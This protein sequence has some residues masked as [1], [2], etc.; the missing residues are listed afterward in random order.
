MSGPGGPDAAEA[1]HDQVHAGLLEKLMAAVRPEFRAGVLT[2]DPRDPVFGGPPCAVPGCER[3][4]RIRNLCWGHRQRW[5]QAGKPDLAVFTA[6]T[7]PDWAGHRPPPACEVPGCNYSHCGRGL[8]QKH[9]QQ[10]DRAGCP[11]SAA[12]CRPWT[13][14]RPCRHRMPAGC[15]P[16]AGGRC[17]PRRSATPTAR[18]GGAQAGQAPASSPPPAPIPASGA[19]GSTCAASWA[20]C[21]WR[22]ST[23]CNAAGT[24]ASRGCARS[25]CSRSCGTWPPREPPRCWNGQKNNGRKPG[26]AASGPAAA[27]SSPWTPVPGSSSW[28]SAAAG[29]WSTRETSGGCATWESSPGRK[30][31][32][33]TSRR[34]ASHG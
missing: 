23:C 31:P 14:C 4:A 11:A 30:S 5:H 20:G 6:A 21:G 25:R 18:A 17:R 24:S 29:K 8:C 3:P 32:P 16:A 34:S 27:A 26:R 28:P 1:G 19:S 9:L 12:G 2:F 7:S 13:T 15:P 33:S 22:S 10:W